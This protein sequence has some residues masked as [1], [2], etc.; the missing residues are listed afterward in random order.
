MEPQYSKN[1]DQW[2][3]ILSYPFL[4]SNK[5]SSLSRSFYIPAISKWDQYYVQYVLLRNKKANFIKD[6]YKIPEPIKEQ[7]S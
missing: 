7:A 3:I 1:R 5:L 4:D 2:D 6:P